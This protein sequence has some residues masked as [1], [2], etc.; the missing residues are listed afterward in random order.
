MDL[1]LAAG[2]LAQTTGSLYSMPDGFQQHQHLQHEHEQQAGDMELEQQQGAPDAVALAALAASQARAD[3]LDGARLTLSGAS[4]GLAAALA[5]LCIGTPGVAAVGLLLLLC[6]VAVPV[7]LGLMVL[8]RNHWL[9]LALRYC[10]SVAALQHDN[11]L[12]F[13]RVR[14]PAA[15][16]VLRG[17]ASVL[18]ALIAGIVAVYLIVCY[19]V[20]CAA[21][22]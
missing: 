11:G 13:A 12:A 21:L 14:W 1:Q 7:A 19:I 18:L 2:P 5:A 4:L 20:R 6:I 9:L 10:M 8:A 17:A 22:I 3:A 15:R 16:T